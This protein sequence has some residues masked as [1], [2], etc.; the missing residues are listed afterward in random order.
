[1]AMLV[2]V[3]FLAA[4]CS[5]SSDDDSRK[6]SG[7]NT[8]QTSGSVATTDVAPNDRPATTLDDS[9]ATTTTT[10]DHGTDPVVTQPP[11]AADTGSSTLPAGWPADVVIP[12]GMVITRSATGTDGTLTVVTTCT[13]KG[14][15]ALEAITLVLNNV[16]YTTK[17]ILP[18][19]EQAKPAVVEGTSASVKVSAAITSDAQGLCQKVEFTAIP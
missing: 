5:S 4:A 18:G 17:W 2:T 14:S 16:G 13:G 8:L 6:S 15:T 1:M 7:A 19:N 11:S 10:P 12:Q 3:V 9:V